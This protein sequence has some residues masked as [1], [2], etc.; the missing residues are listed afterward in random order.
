MVFPHI[1]L[2]EAASTL[3]VQERPDAI[4][5]ELAPPKSEL[6]AL[7]DVLIGSIGLSGVLALAG[8]LLGLIVGSLMFWAR[9]RSAD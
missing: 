3:L 8:V 6:A 4:I 1:A 9:H 7:S 5:V 2:V